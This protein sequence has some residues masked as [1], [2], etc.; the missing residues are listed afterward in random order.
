MKSPATKK[1]YLFY[2]NKYRQFVLE[3]NIIREDTKLI[4]TQVIDFLL[5]LK[6]KNL[7]HKTITSN[8]SAIMHFYTMNDIILNRRKITKFINTDQ[9]KRSKN[10]GYTS[11]QIHKVL[12]ISDER[13]KAIILIYA[14]TGIRLAALPSLR[15]KDL[16]EI[17]LDEKE[18][19][20][21]ITIY[22]GYQEEYVTFCTPECYRAI[23]TY[24]SYR[25]RSGEVIK[26]NSPLIREQ[27]DIHDSFKVKHAAK[28][29]DIK[30]ISK[31]IRQK[32]IQS[33]VREI[34]PIGIGNKEGSKMR[35]DVPLIHGFRKFFNTA[36]MNADV[37][38]SIKELLMGHS[39]K[40]DDVYYHKDSEK[41]KQKLLGEYYKAIDPLTIN[42]ENRLKLEN[43][44]I[45]QRNETLERDKDEV[46]LLRKELEPLL[47]L[48]KTLEEQGLLKVSS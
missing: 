43:Q 40:L 33:G 37:H 1:M 18:K 7:S 5:Y 20:Y 28:A 6:T 16:T 3:E 23:D 14:S 41:S 35:K 21:R 12:E 48:K 39:I 19:L 47:V 34:E 17:S 15:M 4:E 22:E 11:E 8:L 26:P 46:I 30:T 24:L 27:F 13:L 9:K 31:I 42:E 38:Y 45:K 2:F 44:Q 32:L 25:V 10:A 29:I 36:L